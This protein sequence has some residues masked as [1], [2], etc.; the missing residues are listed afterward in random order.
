MC[1]VGIHGCQ[2]KSAFSKAPAAVSLWLVVDSGFASTV[3]AVHAVGLPTL[4]GSDRESPAMDLGGVAKG[5]PAD[6]LLEFL[7]LGANTVPF[8]AETT[9]Q[10]LN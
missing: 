10:F 9:S 6:S 1:S 5:L 2:F 3:L 7:V 8:K 4:P